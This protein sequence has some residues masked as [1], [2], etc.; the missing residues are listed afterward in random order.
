MI[1]ESTYV[2]DDSK[3][4]L[5]HNCDMFEYKAEADRKDTITGYLA[6]K[7]VD[8]ANDMFTEE[9]LK[10]MAKQVNDSVE[11]IKVIYQDF[12]EEVLESL[13]NDGSMGN[14]DHNNHPNLFPLGDL[15][16]VPAFR[17]MGAEYDGFGIKVKA[18]LATEAHPGDISE[19]IRVAVKSKYINAMSIE[20]KPTEVEERENN[21]RVIKSAIVN[22][23]AM[24]G[25]PINS[26]ARITNH[27][28]KSYVTEDLDNENTTF[29][30]EIKSGVPSHQ[31][32]NGYGTT[33]SEEWSAPD[34]EDFKRGFG[35]EEER[36]VD[37]S[38]DIK[39]TIAAHFAYMSAE[40]IEGAEFSDLHFPH[41][42][43]LAEGDVDRAG[44]IAAR[45]R[46]KQSDLSMAA[47]EAM[48]EHLARHLRED[49]DE[50]D[51]ELVLK[52]DITTKDDN[53]TE[54]EE[55]AQE[56]EQKSQPDE[57][58]DE[59]ASLKEEMADIKSAVDK[60]KEQ[61]KELKSE[62]E[63]LKEKLDDED[64]LKSVKS[65]ISDLLGDIKSEI[66]DMEPEDKPK[67]Q[68]ENETKSVDDS[69]YTRLAGIC[70]FEGKS[71]VL[72]N[73]G[74]YGE[75]VGLDEDEVKSYVKEL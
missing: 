14:I 59:V 21:V 15:R 36:F 11:H 75:Q 4:I 58:E 10:S 48:D 73:A 49:F 17:I 24:T 38:D 60:L 45:Q 3:K 54:E 40:S 47:K 35:Y 51:V 20:F 34:F 31:P 71:S 52:S 37:V 33:E 67:T 65:D 42:D 74:E 56:Q 68:Q 7:G 32:L 12:D 66:E 62:N 43:A 29:E 18:K 50:E 1:S 39:R 8:S 64:E 44:V 27:D 46:L 9:A 26:K 2:I 53:M 28:L 57:G 19:A 5:G 61:N 70:K 69:K 72:E 41:H 13:K 55:K 6:T 22:G 23:A 30:K 63:E 25:R 16:T